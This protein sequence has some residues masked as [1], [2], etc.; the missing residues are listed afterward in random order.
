MLPDAAVNACCVVSY[1]HPVVRWLL[2]DSLHPGGLAL[3]TRVADLLGIDATSRLLDAGSGR[4]ASAVHLAKTVGCHVTGVTLEEE[5]VAAGYDLARQH[6]VEERVSFLAGDIR[7]VAL[8]EGSF[9]AVLMECVL[10]ILSGKGAALGRLHGLLRPGGRLGLTDVTVQGELPSEFQGVLALAGC[11][12]GAQSLDG[13]GDLAMVAGFEVELLQDLS[14]VAATFLRDIRGKLLMAKVAVKL[15][16]FAL[17]GGLLAQ[18]EGLLAMVEALVG[19]GALS[20]G[21]VVARKAD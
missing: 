9:D 12:G 18:G 16:K 8:P 13:Y 21:L 19:E 15:G 6:V 14:S 2:G 7:E 10:S 3:T 4:G 17:D 11:V 1:T 5:G 20:Y